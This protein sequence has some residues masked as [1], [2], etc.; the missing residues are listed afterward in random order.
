MSTHE[1]AKAI[2]PHLIGKYTE[3]EHMSNPYQ[4]ARRAFEYAK[5][6]EEVTPEF[7]PTL[8]AIDFGVSDEINLWDET[9]M[10]NIDLSQLDVAV[11]GC[12]DQHD[13]SNFFQEDIIKTD[14]IETQ[15][16]VNEN[17]DVSSINITFK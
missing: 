4:A 17:V 7:V 1:L 12:L 14:P 16:K 13:P 3:Y 5:A 8:G 15:L 2:F 11:A 6:F 10:T 9:M